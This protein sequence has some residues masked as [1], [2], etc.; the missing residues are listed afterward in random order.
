V[1]DVAIRSDDEGAGNHLSMKNYITLRA[2]PDTNS[3]DA[4]DLSNTT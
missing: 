1:Q 3:Q 4:S 2:K